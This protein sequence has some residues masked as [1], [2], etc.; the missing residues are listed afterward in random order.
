[1]GKTLIRW[2]EGQKKKWRRKYKLLEKP[3]KKGKVALIHLD[4]EDDEGSENDPPKVIYQEIDAE[5]LNWES[6]D[7]ELE[8]AE[9][10]PT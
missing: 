6:E 5:D 3:S 4:F 2:K 10:S 9:A 8:G 7:E 1:M